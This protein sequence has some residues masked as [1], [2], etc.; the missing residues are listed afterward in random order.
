MARWVKNSL[1]IFLLF[2]TGCSVN[3]ARRSP[4]DVKRLE[5]LSAE[6]NKF[7]TLAAL[8][9]DEADRLKQ[10]K[11]R[12]EEE[13]SS[14]EAKIGY[15]E[16]GLVARLLDQVLFASGKADLN[17]RAKSV[18]NRVAKVLNEFPSQPVGVEGHT[19]NQP[20]K[21]SGWESNQV[22][23][24]ARAKTVMNYLITQGVDRNRL[25]PVG[26]GEDK[27]IALNDTAAGRQKNRRVE[28][29]IMPERSKRSY[30]RKAHEETKRLNRYSK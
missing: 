28:I 14:S 15:D 8:K 23:S 16:R 5:E 27:P 25:T 18:L 30:K 21:H 29:I 3:F 4:W 11:S 24:M 9:S 22:L 19:D 13:L 10:L 17:A 26:Y 7:K 20:I 2:T 12:L 1:V 6:L